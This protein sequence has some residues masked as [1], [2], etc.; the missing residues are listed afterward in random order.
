MEA[1]E[2]P[3]CFKETDI[4]IALLARTFLSLGQER[5]DD[6]TVFIQWEHNWRP[7]NIELDQLNPT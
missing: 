7:V 6:F 4:D 3:I 2:L 5:V 1:K